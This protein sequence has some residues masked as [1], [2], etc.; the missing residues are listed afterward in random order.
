MN[1]TGSTAQDLLQSMLDA[2]HDDNGTNS[3]NGAYL[4]NEDIIGEVVIFILAGYETISNAI[5]YTAYLLALNPSTQ[6]RLIREINDYYDVNPDCSLYD[7][8]ENIEYVTMVLSESMR[9]YPPV[10]RTAMQRM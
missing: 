9:I 6:D 8:A 7:G 1:T 4:S 10:P 2:H 5:S 3:A